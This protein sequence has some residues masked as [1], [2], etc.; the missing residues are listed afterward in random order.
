MKYRIVESIYRDEYGRSSR[1]D[2][3]IEKKVS[4]IGF[5]YWKP[6]EHEVCDTTGCYRV[7]TYFK[8]Y[9]D[10][11]EFIQEILCKNIKTANWNK[12]VLS[13]HNC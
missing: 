10:A 9:D 5:K 7:T 3:Y 8:V 13:Y 6:I 12:E 4:F 11:K 1:R 2:Y